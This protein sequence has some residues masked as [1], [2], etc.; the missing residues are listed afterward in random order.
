[1]TKRTRKLKSIQA[2]VVYYLRTS[3]EEVQAPTR[4][5]GAQRRDIELNLEKHY[6][7][8]KLHEYIDNFTGTLADR[9]HYQLMLQKAR[10]GEFSEI[11]VQTP[12]RLGRDDVEALRAIDELTVLGVR[13]RF[14]L[15]PELDPAN[16][17]DRFYLN[18]LFGMAR[19]ESKVTARRTKGGMMSKY[20][21]GEWPHGAPDGY[22]NRERKLSETDGSEKLDHAR[23]K[24]WVE[25]DPVQAEVWR[26]AW[27]LL[28]TNRY[29]L[30]QICTAL[31]EY[32]YKMA[33]GRP[34]M[35]ID[36][37]GH[38]R[39]YIQ[40]LSKV[41]H[42][43]FYA[44]WVCVD[45]AIAH[46][47]PKTIRGTWEAIVSTEE[48]ERGLEILAARIS[49]PMPEKKHF[50]LL[51]SLL[52]LDVG[53]GEVVKMR[54]SRSN[55]SRPAG[56]T[57]YYKND[58]HPVQVNCTTIDEQVPTW[59]KQIQVKPA[60]I[61]SIRQ[62]YERDIF[63]FTGTDAHE[64]AKLHIRLHKL[65]EKEVNIWRALT[66][67]RMP[68]EIHAHLAREAANE[69]QALQRAIESLKKQSKQ[70]ISNL[71][72]AL[73]II[74][75]IYHYF[76]EVVPEQQRAILL[77]MVDKIVINATGKILRV[78]LLPPFGYLTSLK[79]GT[80][81][82]GV[83]K[84]STKDSLLSLPLSVPTIVAN[85]PQLDRYESNAIEFSNLITYSQRLILEPLLTID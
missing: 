57:A 60:H 84:L 34:F 19:R 38:T 1:M 9:K 58:V 76:Q 43:W 35:W 5:Q 78:E 64:L 59:L 23:Y 69:K 11:W 55:P 65:E 54:C 68:A 51:Q 73:D 16:E 2:G 63:Q 62:D 12:D 41:F 67:T 26:Y 77:L 3:N 14:A 4:S 45:N 42:N 30:E 29:S 24:R 48:F 82:G 31:H 7:F 8:T 21:R 83:G 75:H 37:Q 18:I 17:D 33:S 85:E 25:L 70:S 6:P 56:G 27:R 15:H 74:A 28:L 53:S 52:Y 40:Q 80:R 49:N 32:G 22:V 47:P 79:S 50:Y 66:E 81:G 13:V 10:I 71:D 36:K 72:T 39:C 46:I 20:T 44:G 61:K